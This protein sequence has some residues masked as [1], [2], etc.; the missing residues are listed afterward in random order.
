MDHGELLK[1]I[2]AAGPE[3]RQ[4]LDAVI[5][6]GLEPLQVR[7]PMRAS[8][9]AAKHFYLSAESSYEEQ[10]WQAY[11]F[12]VGMLDAM[13]CDEIEEV[14]IMKSAR[15]G[16]TKMALAV[17]G[18][19][20][21]HKRR[22]QALYQPTDDDRDEFVTTELE[23]MLRDVP[24][25]RRVFP[26]FNRKSKDNTLKVKR[27]M[28]CLLHTRGGKAAK[29]YRRLTVDTVI[30][31]ELDGFDADVEKEGSPDKL[32]WKRTEGAV[33]RKM[34]A[35]TTPKLR[36]FSL[37]EARAD[38]AELRMRYQVPCTHCGERFALTWGGKDV[39][40]GMKWVNDDPDSV[41]QV[42]PH[43]GCG[44][45][46]TQADYLRAWQHGRWVAQDGTWITADFRFIRID[47]NER[48]AP[49][50][51]AFHVWT[52]Y[53]P[54]TTWSAIVREFMAAADKAKRG[55]KSDL[56]TF[57]N[58]TL[59]ETWEEEVEKTEASALAQ[60]AKKSATPYSVGT[61]PRGGLV[62]ATGVDVQSDRWELVTWA[63]GRGEEM[64]AIDYTVVYGNPGDQREWE[65]KLAPMLERQFQHRNGPWMAVKAAAI[66]TGGHF[67]HQA[68]VFT[69]NHSNKSCYAIKGESRPGQPIKGRKSFVDVNERGRVIKRGAS[70]WL[71]GTDTAKD[72]LHGRFAVAQPGPGYVHFPLDM[73]ADFYTQ[74]TSE[75]RVLARTARGDDYRWI[76]PS[77]ARNEV[78]DCTVY[79]LFC[80]QALD[81]HKYSDLMWQR[82]ESALEPDLF[83]AAA[84]PP[85]P[86]LPM[87]NTIVPV[88]SAQH[89]PV[90][91][92]SSARMVP[93]S[94][95]PMAPPEWNR[96]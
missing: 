46:M 23:P 73:P 89:A 59:G 84:P 26:K 31:D 95:T 4:A 10:C 63:F 41:A 96:L 11:P 14:D 52:A 18:Y 62:L 90:P 92:Q 68:Y 75:S 17:V 76:K 33:F 67:T 34:I 45:L 1:V 24:V 6:R 25:M 85:A 81:L 58:T 19:M 71:V 51:I 28:G 78:L 20:A 83:D 47:G 3:L 7:E 16:Y 57:V 88:T 56:K 86:T 69:R 27:F 38:R 79:A 9:W 36:G 87:G 32:A 93:V 50:H 39:A 22:N 72:L 55:D 48:P 8:E 35:G 30:L 13:G 42:C 12:Q 74:I 44:G 5:L 70:L 29:N 77:G 66:D 94:S 2:D 80:A 60:R 21:E 49:C 37:I 40:T 65:A 53:S 54:Q 91:V 61:V 15:V 82:L 64:W 43:D